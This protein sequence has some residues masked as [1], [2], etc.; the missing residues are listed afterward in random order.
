MS[1]QSTSV[2]VNVSSIEPDVSSQTFPL[3]TFNNDILTLYRKPLERI[4]DLVDITILVV[5]A[6]QNPSMCEEALLTL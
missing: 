5:Y 2:S 4:F 1:E 6:S 3:A